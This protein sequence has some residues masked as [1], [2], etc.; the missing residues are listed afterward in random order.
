MP[1]TRS[2]YQEIKD[3]MIAAI[4]DDTYPPGT[5]LP[6][7]VELAETLGCARATVNRAMRELAAEGI[8]ERK[9]KAGSRV[10]LS[11]TR[12]AKFV[13]PIVRD[14]IEATGATYR[15]A[16]IHASEM[17]A[18]G[19]LKA[20]LSLK[21]DDRVLHLVCMH[22]A[23][24]RPFQFEERWINLRVVP[25]ARDNDFMTVGPNEW[26]VG[27]VPLTD[28]KLTFSACRAEPEVAKFLGER[29]D[30]AHFSV[31]RSTWLEG[32]AV[33]FAR[34]IYRSGYQMTT[35]L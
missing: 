21:P 27:E 16:L 8:I 26:L 4:R 9:R 14:E 19:W 35:M 7:E 3:R 20:R 1:G 23:D 33:T 6:G 28:V 30:E 18:P 11:R 10:K 34:M 12:Q 32:D 2:S 22:F 5:M 29:E 24:E 17:P 31:E 25:Q 15:Y 13:I